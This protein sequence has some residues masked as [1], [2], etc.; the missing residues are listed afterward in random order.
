MNQA[1]SRVNNAESSPAD[2]YDW[3]TAEDV[4]RH[5]LAA[6]YVA[7]RLSQPPSGE[8]F[9]HGDLPHERWSTRGDFLQNLTDH[10]GDRVIK[11]AHDAGVPG[12]GHLADAADRVSASIADRGAKR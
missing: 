4:C 3:I 11:Q 10:F 7:C 6:F 9:V 1:I 2:C 12:L 8:S 5:A